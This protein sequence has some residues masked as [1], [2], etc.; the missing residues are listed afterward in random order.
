MTTTTTNS[1]LNYQQH[2][3]GPALSL[4]EDYS[5]FDRDDYGSDDEDYEQVLE[6][7][8]ENHP[9]SSIQTTPRR[10]TTTVVDD[11]AS[12]VHSPTRQSRPRWTH[13]FPQVNYPQPPLPPPPVS[14]PPPIPT[15]G[16]YY[17]NINYSN[18]II[19]TP[20]SYAA[21]RTVPRSISFRAASSTAT[22]PT[23]HREHDPPLSPPS[24]LPSLAAEGDTNSSADTQ[25][26]AGMSTTLSSTSAIPDSP[27]VRSQNESL[28][29]RGLESSGVDRANRVSDMQ[30]ATPVS[31]RDNALA[32]SST[33]NNNNNNNNSGSSSSSSNSSSSNSNGQGRRTIQTSRR[34]V[35]HPPGLIYIYPEN[36]API[37]MSGRPVLSSSAPSSSPPSLSSSMPNFASSLSSSL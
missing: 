25:S 2:I 10:Q 19:S 29:Q 33:N 16:S 14:S 4:G 7:L 13:A 3:N 22:A 35:V 31:T 34:S 27:T 18:D 5:Q 30:H 37:I 12:A 17:G 9:R 24:S 8:R 36:H 15:H 20:S 21:M 6:F 32:N 11:A 23:Y 26:A 28:T 1:S